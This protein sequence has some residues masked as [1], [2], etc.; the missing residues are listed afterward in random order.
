M[1]QKVTEQ[2]E[3]IIG[4]KQRPFV[5]PQP[6]AVHTIGTGSEGKALL[7]FPANQN[8]RIAKLRKGHAGAV[9]PL[10][11][12][13]VIGYADDGVYRWHRIIYYSA[14]SSFFSSRN[15]NKTLLISRYNKKI[16]LIDNEITMIFFIFFYFI[17]QGFI[18]FFHNSCEIKE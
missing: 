9:H 2:P 16:Q 6:Q 15:E 18:S 7:Q 17:K 13:E 10:I 12:G 1:R 4:V 5:E 8:H 11:G 14:G 3:V